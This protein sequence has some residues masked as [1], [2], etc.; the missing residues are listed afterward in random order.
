MAGGL[1]TFA[2]LFQNQAYFLQGFPKIPLAVLWDFKDLQYLQT[3]FPL[4]QTFAAR[5]GLRSL[6]TAPQGDAQRLTPEP[7]TTLLA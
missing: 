4:L 7:P 5:V 6:A 3:H 1:Q 2:K